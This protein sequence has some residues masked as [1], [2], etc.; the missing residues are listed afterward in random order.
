MDTSQES[1]ATELD[2]HIAQMSHEIGHLKRL[3]QEIDPVC[4]P[5]HDMKFN[6]FR[7]DILYFLREFKA[8]HGLEDS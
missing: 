6:R 8:E 3:C 7:Q 5:L 2:Y 4:A 1:L